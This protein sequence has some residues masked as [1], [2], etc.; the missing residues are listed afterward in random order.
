MDIPK[1]YSRAQA[2]AAG[3]IINTTQYPWTGRIS[4]GEVNEIPI[5]VYTDLEAALLQALS[6]ARRPYLPEEVLTYSLIQKMIREIEDELEMGHDAPTLEQSVE[7]TVVD[8]TRH[9]LLGSRYEISSA[10]MSDDEF[11]YVVI[12]AHRTIGKTSEYRAE[13]HIQV[14]SQELVLS[15]RIVHSDKLYLQYDAESDVHIE[16]RHTKVNYVDMVHQLRAALD[17]Q[18]ERVAAAEGF[19]ANGRTQAAGLVG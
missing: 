7:E 12:F 6:E 8:A 13:M 11:R 9:A 5:E 19:E 15:G 17:A 1:R 16:P 4:G 3:F 18:V 10:E 2:E 14:G